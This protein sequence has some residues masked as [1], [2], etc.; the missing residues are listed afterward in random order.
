MSKTI[1]LSAG[2][3]AA[4]PGAVSR[5]GKLKEAALA[6]RLRNAVA[7]L[8]RADGVTVLTDGA[9]GVNLPLRDAI[10]LVKRTKNALAVE[11]HFNAA[12]PAAQGVEVLC[13]DEHK[14]FAQDLA[15]AISSVTGSPLRGVAGW[16]SDS[17]G[18]HH[19]LG[20]CDAGGL[21]IEAEFIS[22]P[23]AMAAYLAKE[24]D[25]AQSLAKVLRTYA[26]KA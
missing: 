8:L 14:R 12:A 7:A 21:I 3:S 18:Q 2:H 15:L 13:K 26:E 17:S 6:Q 25:V 23:D 5:D 16:K 20:F 10:A 24:S 22:N 19:R 4:D 11:I 1:I 9:D